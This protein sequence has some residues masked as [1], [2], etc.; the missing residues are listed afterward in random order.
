[1]PSRVKDVVIAAI[2]LKS[3]V[4]AGAGC[5]QLLR[6][7][8]ATFEARD[9]GVPTAASPLAPS[10]GEPPRE[11]PPPP[12]ECGFVGDPLYL[13]AAEPRTSAWFGMKVAVNDH[14]L[15]VSAPLER[16]AT[17]HA[18]SLDAD[19]SC[20]DPGAN[21]N[22]LGAGATRVFERA[23]AWSE[24]KLTV[25]GGADIYPLVPKD[26][27]QSGLATLG[28]FTTY[29]LAASD[30][31]VVVGA[32]GDSTDGPYQGSVRLFRRVASNGPWSE[33]GTPLRS[34]QPQPGEKYLFGVA[35]ALSGDTL[36]VGAPT[37]NGG[38]RPNGGAVYVYELTD[39]GTSFVQ[40]LESPTSHEWGWFG[41]S[42]AISN[43]WLVVGAPGEQSTG[44]GG[45]FFG[46]A[47]VFR[48]NGVQL[49]PAGVTLVAPDVGPTAYFGAATAIAG[50]RLVVSAPGLVCP[51]HGGMLGGS[52]HPFSFASGTWQPETCLD[53]S[54]DSATM[55]FGLSLAMTADAL[56]VGAPVSRGSAAGFAPDVPGGP[57]FDS[58]GSVY[59]YR[60]TGGGL[61]RPGCRVKAPNPDPC[62]AFGNWVALADDYFAVGAPLEDGRQGGIGPPD[63]HNALMD[64]GGVYIYPLRLAAP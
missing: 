24:E 33:Q 54:G 22:V 44:D 47:H 50:E 52:V 64:S 1:M 2:F 17:P 26:S 48:R 40:R 38:G 19:A 29:G 31:W 30:D 46:S 55:F 42:V 51:D 5:S 62:D 21:M 13:K 23:N 7:D 14:R 49:D 45:T 60:L 9:A 63:R 4:L 27:F 61:Q 10:L 20:I 16:D 56:V 18:E 43:D 25:T 36:V 11:V 6:S 35:V 3:A 15:I 34:S 57:F 41:T 28:N 12:T 58:S 39:S 32:G 53:E 8:D 37:E 59:A